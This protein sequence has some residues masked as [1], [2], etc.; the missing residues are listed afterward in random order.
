MNFAVRVGSL[1]FSPNGKTLAIRFGDR[2]GAVDRRALR[3]LDQAAHASGVRRPLATG[4]DH[5]VDR[6][7]AGRIIKASVPA[8]TVAGVAVDRPTVL[9]V[10]GEIPANQEGLLRLQKL[11]RLGRPLCEPREAAAKA[12]TGGRDLPR[13]GPPL[14]RRHPR[15]L[16]RRA[17]V[18]RRGRGA[19]VVS[20]PPRPS[21]GRPCARFS[22]GWRTSTG[23]PTRSAS[24]ARSRTSPSPA[25]RPP[26][27]VRS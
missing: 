4:V 16:S 9:P 2:A 17:G 6:G 5:A 10:S 3:R 13:R 11:G 7:S 12:S 15:R 27:A 1:S 8:A 19:D 20:R 22:W 24:S 21:A 23:R 18:A 25:T 26:P 14:L